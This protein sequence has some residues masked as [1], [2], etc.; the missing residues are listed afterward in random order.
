[1]LEDFRLQFSSW[2]KWKDRNS[3]GECLKYPGVY[4][5]AISEHDLTGNDFSLISEIVYIGMTNSM[6]G[7]K[8]RLQQFDNTLHKKQGHGGAQRVI[9]NYP[10][11]D[12]E[13]LFSRLFVSIL[14]I[15]CNVNPATYT[16]GDLRKMGLVADLEYECFA[17]YLE[18][19]HKL[20]IYNDKK[21]SPKTKM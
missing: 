8:S 13:T 18:E 20:P 15:E 12:Y 7:L 17:R 2:K 10:D 5:L 21:K 1:L 4:S 6:G 11:Y 9:S 16:P 14:P 3:F 19:Y